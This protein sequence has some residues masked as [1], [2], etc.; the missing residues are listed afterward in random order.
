MPDQDI[1]PP[2]V[3]LQGLRFGEDMP[4]GGVNVRTTDREE[5]LDALAASILA[6]GLLVPLIVVPHRRHLYVVAGNRRLAAL[7]KLE[8]DGHLPKDHPVRVVGLEPG[9]NP[10]EAS[11]AENEV[12][13]DMNPID[14]HEGFAR[15]AADGLDAGTIASHFG[16]PEL[17]VRQS[18]ALGGRISPRIRQAWREGLPTEVVQAFTIV[19]DHALQDKV[20]EALAKAGTLFKSAIWRALTGI[21]QSA[22]NQRYLDLVGAGAFVRAGGRLVE[23]LFEPD[24]PK[25]LDP[26]LLM[27]LTRDRIEAECFRLKQEGWDW[28]SWEQDL[29]T[30]HYNWAREEEFEPTFRLDE[31]EDR[32]AYEELKA[33]A[34]GDVGAG[35]PPDAADQAMALAELKRFLRGPVGLRCCPLAIRMR[36]GCKIRVDEGGK[37]TIA[38]GFVRPQARPVSRGPEPTSEAAE[39]AAP[40]APV[41]SDALSQSLSEQRTVAAAGALSGDPEVALRLLVAALQ[42]YRSPA[43]IYARGFSG[44]YG[45]HGIGSQTWAHKRPVGPTFIEAF[46]L[47]EGSSTHT[48]LAE[49]AGLVAASLDLTDAARDNPG[50]S[51]TGQDA[52]VDALDPQIY[53]GEARQAFDPENYFDRIASRAIVAAIVEMRGTNTCQSTR[54]P[55]LVLHAAAAA[56]DTGWLPEQLRCAA[57]VLP[58]PKPGEAA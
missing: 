45:L 9:V 32:A 8:A 39:V 20:Y 16:R 2:T 58:T 22:S 36:T 13:E 27:R 47:T 10:N 28:A 57:Y 25:I 40:S 33:R 3:P 5:G 38:F 52:V 55:D 42:A 21:E 34:A 51:V 50:I 48:L 37:L 35:V 1:L 46:A 11:L 12:R 53:L 56:R 4:E 17:T 7:R 43:R 19:A 31:D 41:V 23:D 18:V 54:K 24:A 49:L 26:E 29:P 15:L 44:L 30:T 6:L 14:V